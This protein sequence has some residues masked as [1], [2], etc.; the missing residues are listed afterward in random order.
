MRRQVS[1]PCRSQ[2]RSHRR[3][4]GRGGYPGVVGQWGESQSLRG[5][6]GW[7]RGTHEAEARVKGLLEDRVRRVEDELREQ[8]FV[9]AF[10]DLRWNSREGQ[11]AAGAGQMLGR[12]EIGGRLT[13]NRHMVLARAAVPTVPRRA[14]SWRGRRMHGDNGGADSGALRV[15]RYLGRGE[16][17]GRWR[18]ARADPG[19]EFAIRVL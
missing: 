4:S 14:R 12:L 6:E 13:R 16:K 1:S 17:D 10:V 5:T 8:N 19:S 15:R 3:C 18:R 9:A 7:F 11:W 2:C